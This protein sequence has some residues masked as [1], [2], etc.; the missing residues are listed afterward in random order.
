MSSLSG[1]P[2][3]FTAAVGSRGTEGSG[4]GSRPSSSTTFHTREER[5]LT[6]SDIDGLTSRQVRRLE[7]GDTIPQ[8][9]TLRRLAAA[10]GMTVDDY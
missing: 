8:I 6:Q 5:G 9:E 1:G 3:R 4:K 2:T 7:E 10:H